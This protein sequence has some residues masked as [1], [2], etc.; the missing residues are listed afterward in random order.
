MASVCLDAL[1]VGLRTRRRS[2][3]VHVR[4]QNIVRQITFCSIILV[5]NPDTYFWW[6]GG[7][8]TALYFSRV[9]VLRHILSTVLCVQFLL[10]NLFFGS[11]ST[12]QPFPPWRVF[13][14]FVVSIVSCGV[15]SVG[16]WSVSYYFCCWC[17]CL[18]C[19]GLPER[20]KRWC[21][22][23]SIRM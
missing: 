18:Q 21:T 3:Q 17:L 12:G 6:C 11:L 16:F 7:G 8:T 14:V 23:S 4:F 13:M 22:L 15:C 5:R 2:S 1:L 20:R 10:S 19:V 9:R